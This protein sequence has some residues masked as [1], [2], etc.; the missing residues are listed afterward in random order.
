ML[1][2]KNYRARL[3]DEND[4]DFVTGLRLSDHVQS[5]VGNVIFTNNSLQKEWVAKVSKSASDKFLVLEITDGKNH[6]RI[7]MIRLSAIDFVNRSMCVGGDIAEEFAGQGHGKIMYA[8]IFKLGFDTWGMNRLWLSVLENNDRAINLYK[9]MGFIDEGAQRK[10]IYK[11]GKY[12]DYLN[13]SI[14]KD[15]YNS[16]K[17]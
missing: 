15:E 4:I 17:K 5:C 3:I 12:L 8:M 6:Q 1:F 14:L 10:A 13:M 2:Y 11:D 9:K 7:G 16:N